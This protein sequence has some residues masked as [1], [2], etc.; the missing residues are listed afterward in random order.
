MN[1]M[2]VMTVRKSVEMEEFE[3]FRRTKIAIHNFAAGIAP[4]IDWNVMIQTMDS[5][6]K[7]KLVLELRFGASNRFRQSSSIWNQYINL[8]LSSV[9]QS[10]LGSVFSFK[11]NL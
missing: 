9:S 2:Q 1:G 3:L 10:L 7:K 6:I 5:Q 11:L 4:Y 8:M